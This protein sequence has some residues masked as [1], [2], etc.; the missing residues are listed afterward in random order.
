MRICIFFA[1][2]CLCAASASAA[3]INGKWKAQ[4]PWGAQ[5]GPGT[6]TVE[7]T[8][9]FKTDGGKITSCS[10]TTPHS[11]LP[12]SKCLLSGDEIS[13]VWTRKGK[14][15]PYN[16]LYK[17]KVSGDEIKGTSLR[18]GETKPREFTAKR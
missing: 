3:D 18:E 15:K 7:M 2:A 10:I 14:D 1:T 13:F 4:M 9:E 5:S 8:L 6:G 16:V 12:L 11:E 17:G